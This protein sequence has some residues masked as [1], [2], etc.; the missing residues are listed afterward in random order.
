MR[1]ES[2]G[3]EYGRGGAA[4][5]QRLGRSQRSSSGES[6]GRHRLIKRANSR[7][8]SMSPR[9]GGIAKVRRTTSGGGR[10]TSGRGF[11]KDNG[12]S[13][14]GSSDGGAGDEG[15]RRFQDKHRSSGT[16]RRGD[17]D[18]QGDRRGSGGDKRRRNDSH[19]GEFKRRIEY[20]MP[21]LN[22][23]I[24]PF[25]M[26]QDMQIQSFSREEFQKF[27]DEYKQIHEKKQAEYFFRNHS[28][29]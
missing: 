11:P 9:S 2:G 26:F 22:E 15:A 6:G 3:A 19:E 13:D 4:S 27:Y 17:D 28:N 20:K 12:S 5:H 25:K 21:R 16:N 7:S 23:P 10:G 29:E 24:I 18:Y 14:E 1:R 8:R